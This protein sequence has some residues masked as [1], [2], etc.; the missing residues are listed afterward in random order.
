MSY[1]KLVYH[2]VFST[3]KRERTILET[4]E[5]RLYTYI[6]GIVRHL[7]GYVYAMNGMPDHIHIL[8]DIP[9]SMS[10]SDFVKTIKQSSSN[11]M[12]EVGNQ[13]WNGWEKGYSIFS[14]SCSDFQRVQKYIEHQKS[15]HE[16]KSFRE[17]FIAFLKVAGVE[18]DEKY[19]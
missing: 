3:H 6:S 11:W 18:Y 10:I 17:E 8:L 14:C 12:K 19:L 2:L 13:Y 7:G 15:H 16:K 1:S 4:H 5:Q 9:P